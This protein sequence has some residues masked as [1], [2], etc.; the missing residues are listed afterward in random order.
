MSDAQ[1]GGGGGDDPTF[2]GWYVNFGW[3]I[4]GESRPFKKTSGA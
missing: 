1:R 3:F 2:F 4:T